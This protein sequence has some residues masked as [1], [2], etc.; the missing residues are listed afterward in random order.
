[1]ESPEPREQ[2]TKAQ[3]RRNDHGD[4]ASLVYGPSVPPL[5]RKTLA[6]LIK[7]QATRYAEREAVIV[8][9]QSAR[10]TYARLGERSALVAK[11]LLDTAVKRG[12][13]VGIMAGNCYQYI[14]IFLGAGRIGSPVAVFNNTFSPQELDTMIARTGESLRDASPFPGGI[15]LLSLY[16]SYKAARCSSLLRKSGAEAWLA[17]CRRFLPRLDQIPRFVTLFHLMNRPGLATDLIFEVIPT[18]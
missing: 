7:E 17:M 10:L 4:E 18:S 13:C 15:S 1:M 8:P 3:S 14:E 2:P 11:A 9:W 12:D 6:E 16:T 5:W